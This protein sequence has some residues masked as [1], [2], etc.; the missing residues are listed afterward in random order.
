MTWLIR[1]QRRKRSACSAKIVRE[2]LGCDLRVCPAA[3]SSVFFLVVVC[4]GGQTS[5]P[6]ISSMLREF[7]PRSNK[8]V[9][10]GL[11]VA[12]V[13]TLK[14]AKLARA[15]VRRNHAARCIKNPDHSSM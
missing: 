14:L 7:M 6:R 5:K 3:F 11:A 13:L 9:A 2:T 4:E 15:L 10:D 8:T 12:V 1:L